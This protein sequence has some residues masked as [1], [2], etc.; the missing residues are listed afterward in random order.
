M[1]HATELLGADVKDAQGNYV[2]RVRELFIAPGDDPG[3]V[4]W[5]LLARG[6]YQPLVARHDQ[7]AS[8]EPGKIG[9]T[10]GEQALESF[11]PND[12]GA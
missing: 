8:A 3:R 1:L 7:V 5:I 11:Q 10:V 2:G 6:R 12:S 4:S 9:L